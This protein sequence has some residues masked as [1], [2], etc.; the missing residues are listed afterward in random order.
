M[1]VGRCR[2]DVHSWKEG[3]KARR[4]IKMSLL[5][6][7]LDKVRIDKLLL[8]NQLHHTI[9]YDLDF[10]YM[11]RIKL[12][13][14]LVAIFKRIFPALFSRH[15]FLNRYSHRESMV[16]ACIVIMWVAVPLGVKMAD[17]LS[18]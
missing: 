1:S 13:Q 9:Q 8:P 4:Y 12:I 11:Y 2:R 6:E 7:H 3:R 10:V 15:F 18:L 5:P 14:S 16:A 17:T